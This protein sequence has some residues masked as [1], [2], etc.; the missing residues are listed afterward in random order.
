MIEMKMS[1]HPETLAIVPGV[2]RDVSSHTFA[3]TNENIFFIGVYH[4]M[5]STGGVIL[6]KA[7]SI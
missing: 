2:S 1:Y 5:S 3:L 4:R 6:T 7:A